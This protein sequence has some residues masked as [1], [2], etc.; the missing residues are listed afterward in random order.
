MNFPGVGIWIK[1]YRVRHLLSR[2]A[3]AAKCG[4]STVT[5]HR[6]EADPSLAASVDTRRKIA[7]ATGIEPEVMFDEIEE[8]AAQTTSEVM[9]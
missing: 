3:F 7:S 4:I 1:R 5:V 8:L 9:A 2:E 6:L